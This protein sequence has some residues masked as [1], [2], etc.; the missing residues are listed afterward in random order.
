MSFVSQVAACVC[1]QYL[2]RIY[3]DKENYVFLAFDAARNAML[4][5]KNATA[6]SNTYET[7]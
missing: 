6:I 4:K 3:L 2:S 1:T 5:E 7:G